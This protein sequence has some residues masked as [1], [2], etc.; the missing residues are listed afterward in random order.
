M[1]VIMITNVKIDLV[2]SFLFEL[3]C[4]SPWDVGV[5]VVLNISV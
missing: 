1:D 3:T 4:L 2:L 5:A